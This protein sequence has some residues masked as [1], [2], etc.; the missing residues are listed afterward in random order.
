MDTTK[1]QSVSKDT[2]KGQ[3]LHPN[4]IRVLTDGEFA[5]ENRDTWKQIESVLSPGKAEEKYQLV[6][7]IGKGSCSVVHKGTRVEGGHAVTIKILNTFVEYNG[8]RKF[9]EIH[10]EIEIMKKLSADSRFPRYLD[11]YV[12]EDKVWL[13]MEHIDGVDLFEALCFDLTKQEVVVIAYNILKALEYMHQKNIMHSDLKEDNVMLGKDG[14]VKLIDFGLSGEI[15]DDMISVNPRY[16]TNNAPEVL[17]GGRFNSTADVWSFGTILFTMVVGE[18]P[19]GNEGDKTRYKQLL[20]AHGKPPIPNKQKLDAGLVDL[21]DQ[22]LT[23]D[24]RER[25]SP[26]QLLGHSI[27]Q[28]NEVQEAGSVVSALV[29]AVLEEDEGEDTKEC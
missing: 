12:V 28:S 14:S 27:F 20:L 29:Q 1:P 7:Q 6:Q 19:F 21:L 26:A 13:V 15:T 23:V 22:C 8:A 24:Y 4:I 11:S 17:K 25:P 5:E 2:T 9:I 3:A 10:E 18:G 16:S